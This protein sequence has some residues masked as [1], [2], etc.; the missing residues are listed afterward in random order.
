MLLFFL[1]TFSALVSTVDLSP[2]Q[3]P[4]E[5]LLDRELAFTDYKQ[6]KPFQVMLF[7]V[8]ALLLQL[9]IYVYPHLKYIHA[10]YVNFCGRKSDFRCVVKK[11]Y[12]ILM[13]E[14]NLNIIIIETQFT[15]TTH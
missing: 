3:Q 12:H 7:V 8:S 2:Q 9:M 1:Q 15:V 13:L 5:F 14:K 4:V 10:V 6:L 11:L